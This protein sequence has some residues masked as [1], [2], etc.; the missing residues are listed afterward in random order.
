MEERREQVGEGVGEGAEVHL[1]RT[2]SMLFEHIEGQINLADTKAQLTVAA[3]TLFLAAATTLGQ[4]VLADV[5]NGAAPLVNR[6]MG[7]LSIVMLALLVFSLLFALLAT[8][9]R[10][11]GSKSPTLYY[12]G[13]IAKS[14]HAEE[15]VASFLRQSPQ[16][17]TRSLATEIFA[18]AQIAQ[19]KFVRVR[20]SINCLIAALVAWA[21]VQLLTLLSHQ[22]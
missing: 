4:G 13:A 14:P 6:A 9:P 21:A 18:K 11:V 19:R 2:A 17:V 12:F 5:L 3:D 20:A 7:A 1:L 10:L 15:Y 8:R 16:D 22:R